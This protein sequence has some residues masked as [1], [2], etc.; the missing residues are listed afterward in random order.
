MILSL[1]FIIFIINMF[2]IIRNNE[3]CRFRISI[4]NKIPLGHEFLK[5]FT[6][7]EKLPTYSQ[8]LLQFWVWPLSKYLEGTT[9][10]E[11]FEENKCIQL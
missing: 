4:M 5:Y 2:L 10:K 3:V 6:E 1:I 9:L 8:M 7:Y 11:L